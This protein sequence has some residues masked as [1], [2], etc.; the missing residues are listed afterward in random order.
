[1]F[2]TLIHLV[3]SRLWQDNIH[4]I[5]LP[6]QSH[7][8]DDLERIQVRIELEYLLDNRT[9]LHDGAAVVLLEQTRTLVQDGRQFC[10]WLD[11]G[12]S[13][14]VY[15]LCDLVDG[16]KFE[17]GKSLSRIEVPDNAF[18]LSTKPIRDSPSMM[19]SIAGL[20]VNPCVASQALIS[21]AV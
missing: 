9:C 8:K 17:Q 15:H 19:P 5:L 12:V 6:H 16:K 10:H 7:R 18:G 1:V 14:L 11:L 4:A 3:W 2:R 20:R 13:N 21:A